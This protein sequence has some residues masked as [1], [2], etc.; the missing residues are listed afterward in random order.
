MRTPARAAPR[1]TLFPYS[2]AQPTTQKQLAAQSNPAEANVHIAVEV[3][4]FGH[5]ELCVSA[6]VV[7]VADMVHA[8]GLD[9]AVLKKI[10]KKYPGLSF[11]HFVAAMKLVALARCRELG[12][13]A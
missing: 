10:L 11:G 6:R 3:E 7:D 1:L 8:D 5:A 2:N 12:G 9:L 4:G 13:Q